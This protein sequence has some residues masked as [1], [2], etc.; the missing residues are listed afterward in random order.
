MDT[1]GEFLYKYFTV[2]ANQLL[3]REVVD[4]RDKFVELSINQHYLHHVK[5]KVDT[6]LLLDRMLPQSSLTISK[7]QKNGLNSMRTRNI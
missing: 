6:K 7:K 5:M 4:A 2:V 1:N 3:I